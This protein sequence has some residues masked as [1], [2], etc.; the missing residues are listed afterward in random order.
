MKDNII[1]LKKYLE[2]RNIK[3]IKHSSCNKISKGVKNLKLVV[4]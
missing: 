1:I 4:N 2:L 3:I